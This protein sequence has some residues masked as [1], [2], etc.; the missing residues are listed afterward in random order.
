MATGS[1]IQSRMARAMVLIEPFGSYELWVGR[2]YMQVDG[3]EERLRGAAKANPSDPLTE[4][5]SLT[6]NIKVNLRKAVLTEDGTPPT[7]NT[8]LQQLQ[9]AS[10]ALS[11]LND[12]LEST[13]FDAPPFNGQKPAPPKEPTAIVGGMVGPK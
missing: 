3:V 9:W 10:T 12:L 5:L 13:I 1:E 11:E 4:A 8:A 6:F 7:P 2:I